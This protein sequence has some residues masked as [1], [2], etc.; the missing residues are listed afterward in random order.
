M[1]IGWIGLLL[2][3]LL[4]GCGGEAAPVATPTVVAVDEEGVPVATLST[5]SGALQVGVAG[6][7]CWGGMCADMVGVLVPPDALPVAPDEALTITLTA[8]DASSAHLR[9]L[10]W[11][12]SVNEGPTGTLVAD[13]SAPAVASGE[14]GSGRTLTWNAPLEPGEYIL[15][16]FSVYEQGGDISYGWHIRV[17]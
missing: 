3:L 6:T 4:A 2:A 16:L 14:L 5:P 11:Q 13:P 7:R 15:S 12:A 10:E 9:V 17:E 1:T 8:G